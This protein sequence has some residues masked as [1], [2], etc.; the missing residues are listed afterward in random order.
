MFESNIYGLIYGI[1]DFSYVFVNNRFCVMQ[2]LLL[3]LNPILSG[4]ALESIHL[5][6]NRKFNPGLACSTWLW[7][8]REKD[9]YSLILQEDEYSVSV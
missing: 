3:S 5:R 7:F 9:K 8:T 6:N 1:S 2:Q 4:A